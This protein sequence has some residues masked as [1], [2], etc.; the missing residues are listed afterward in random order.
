MLAELLINAPDIKIEVAAFTDNRGNEDANRKLSIDRAKSVV[1]YLIKKGVKPTC[2]NA[3]GYG[4]ANPIA[5]NDTKEGRE[6]NRRIEIKI[7][8]VEDMKT[9]ILENIYFETNKAVLS[10]ESYPSLNK[11]AAK[12]IANA[13]MKIEICGY[14][15]NSGNETDN[16]QLSQRRAEAVV[17]YLISAGISED[18][19]IATGYGSTNPIAA[20]DTFEGRAK[21]RRIEVKILEQ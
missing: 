8:E 14:T 1:N 6:K 12:M 16:L 15:D 5:S 2:L 7:L 4:E 20:N 17:N 13:K 19:L 3:Q 11:L 21:N 18:R 9:G 10:R